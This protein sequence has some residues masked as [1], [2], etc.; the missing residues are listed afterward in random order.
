MIIKIVILISL[1]KF[2]GDTLKLPVYNGDIRRD[3]SMISV[4]EVFK[5]ASQKRS[6]VKPIHH[7]DTYIYER[8]AIAVKLLHVETD[9]AKLDGFIVLDYGNLEGADYLGEMIVNDT[10]KYYYSSS[11]FVSKGL[12]VKKADFSPLTEKTEKVVLDLLHQH[13]FEE[14]ESMASK[15]GKMHSGTGFYTIGM[16][17]RGMDSVYVNSI[18]AFIVN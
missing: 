6:H 8:R 5:N 12:K 7:L 9:T 14:L 1:L 3:S 16:Y 15:L 18:P 11:Y 10:S 4:L 17:E 13:L 2:G